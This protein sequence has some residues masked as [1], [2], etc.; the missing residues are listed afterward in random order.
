MSSMI[1]R[2]SIRA[3]S[4][5]R[6]TGRGDPA[7]SSARNVVA[8]RPTE[9]LQHPLIRLESRPGL[10]DVGEP[11]PV[12]RIGRLTVGALVGLG[13]VLGL[14]ALGGDDPDIGVGRPGGV[15]GGLGGEGELLAV[16]RPGVVGRA[17]ERGRGGVD[18]EL[19][20][21]VLRLAGLARRR[22]RGGCASP[23]PRRSSGGSSGDHRC[24]PCSWRLP[25]PC[26]WRRSARESDRDRPRR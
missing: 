11:L 22:R 2:I 25:S 24:G 13:Q 1:A 6:T 7:T 16:G 15:V 9:D 23:R 18:L 17:A 4:P 20:R 12:G 26:P 14:A 21:Q 5:R 3:S 10:A 19:G 8:R